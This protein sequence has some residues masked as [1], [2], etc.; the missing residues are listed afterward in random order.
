MGLLKTHFQLVMIFACLGQL[1]QCAAQA[2]P[3]LSSIGKALEEGSAGAAADETVPTLQ[4]SLP[5]NGAVGVAVNSKLTLTFSEPVKGLSI[6]GDNGCSGSLQIYKTG[7]SRCIRYTA[8]SPDQVTFTVSPLF[9]FENATSYQVKITPGVTD[10]AGNAFS[11][12]LLQFTTGSEQDSTAPS[13]S[14]SPALSDKDEIQPGGFT[15]NTTLN[16]AATFFYVAVLNADGQPSAEQVRAGKKQDNSSAELAGSFSLQAN[17]AGAKA[18]TPLTSAGNYTVY[19]YAE[20]SSG[21]K[22]AVVTVGTLTVAAPASGLVAGDLVITEVMANPKAV[23][24]AKGEYL[25]LYNA[26]SA[27][28]NF[29]ETQVE[30]TSGLSGTLSSG[31]VEP[32]SYFLLCKNTD[33]ENNGSLTNCDIQFPGGSLHNNS[34]TITLQA[35]GVNIDSITYPNSVEGKSFE[36]KPGKLTAVNNDDSSNWQVALYPFNGSGQSDWGTPGKVNSRP[37]LISE[38]MRNGGNADNEFIE[39]YNPNPVAINLKDAGYKLYRDSSGGGSPDLLCDFSVSRH[40]NADFLPTALDIPAYGFYL[41]VND[42]A[43]AGTTWRIAADALVKDERMVVN[44]NNILYLKK[45][46]SSLEIDSAILDFVGY[47]TATD[48]DGTG[49]APAI[50]SNG[51]SIERKAY[52]NSTA[53]ADATTGLLE[54]GGHFAMGNSFDSD[55]NSSDFVY[56]PEANP[57]GST[58]AVEQP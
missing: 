41:I 5:A 20:D 13:F 45:S 17:S 7:S 34:T 4:S 44:A 1:W 55:N 16:E 50:A 8:N 32:G 49:A 18:E 23:H 42:N 21:N 38:I 51:G 2:P 22:T 53:D 26:S 9:D 6:S 33:A 14:V 47:G 3:T 31:T 40:F 37:V 10:T 39:L 25:E 19:G 24:D 27:T 57:Q 43:T 12:T 11:D 30:F 28:I 35:N 29:T 36:L 46:A 15:V 56:R 54:G 48:F 52:N 58:S